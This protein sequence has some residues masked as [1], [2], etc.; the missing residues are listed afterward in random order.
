MESEWQ[1]ERS[2]GISGISN[3]EQGMANIEVEV[4]GFTAGNETLCVLRAF[5]VNR[6]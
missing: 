4:P 5:V 6:K 3:D 1:K 2:V